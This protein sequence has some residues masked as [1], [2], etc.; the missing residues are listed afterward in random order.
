MVKSLDITSG[1]DAKKKVLDIVFWGGNPDMWQLITKAS[2]KSE[3]WM[4]STKALELPHGCL[5][6]VSTQ[7]SGAIAEALEFV[8]GVKIKAT[9]D[10]D[11][12]VIARELVPINPAVR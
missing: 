12:T 3:G 5:I 6:N 8:P 10:K 2:S 11:G 4:R 7:V 9:K 1:E